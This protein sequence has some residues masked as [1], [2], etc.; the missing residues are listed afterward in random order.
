MH[1]LPQLMVEVGFRLK[2]TR[3]KISFR[4]CRV[5]W[6]QTSTEIIE[7]SS[8]SQVIKPNSI[9]R[10]FFLFPAGGSVMWTMITMWILRLSSPCSQASPRTATSTWANPV[11]TN[12]LLVRNCWRATKRY[13]TTAFIQSHLNTASNYTAAPCSRTVLGVPR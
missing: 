13:H 10:H 2:S 3:T 12:P 8:R 4:I 11:W 7:S 5:F 1:H 9:V 6:L